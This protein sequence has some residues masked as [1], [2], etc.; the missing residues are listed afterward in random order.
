M[1]RVG[2]KNGLEG[3]QVLP[4]EFF[5]EPGLV[6]WG[7]FRRVDQHRFAPM[8]EVKAVEINLTLFVIPGPGPD[9]GKHF[10]EGL[11]HRSPF[12][13]RSLCPGKGELSDHR[14]HP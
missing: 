4:P 2:Q 8:Q 5:P 12:H 14:V 13:P 7:H 3:R 9:S 10:P 1:M 11:R 6:L